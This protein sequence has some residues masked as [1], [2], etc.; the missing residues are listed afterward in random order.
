MDRLH[1]EHYRPGSL[2]GTIERNMKER[3]AV[4][5]RDVIPP[6]VDLG[7]GTGTGFT[8]LGAETDIIGVDNNIDL[9]RR[10]RQLHPKVT[11]VC[12]DMRFPPFVPGAFQS[13][14]SIATLEHVFHLESFVESAARILADS[15]FFFVMIPTEGGIAW[16]LGRALVTARRNSRLL[17]VDY[18]RVSKM[19][20][21][22]TVFAVQNA[23]EKHF[24]IDRLLQYPLGFGGP[25]CNIA[26]LYR[27][28]KRCFRLDS[29][30][31]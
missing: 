19:D 28:S 12:C 7:C 24:I 16:R 17:G 8:Y 4:L 14:L 18:A 5:M 23:L 26:F 3:M 6:F 20:H 13:L 1:A 25:H 21:C 11:L 2:T 29:S 9:L 31:A 22:N 27:L 30:S 15:G 10:C